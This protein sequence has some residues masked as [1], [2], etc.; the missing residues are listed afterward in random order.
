MRGPEPGQRD[1]PPWGPAAA[2]G[3]AH[4]EQVTSLWSGPSPTLLTLS[5][6]TSSEGRQNIT[7]FKGQIQNLKMHITRKVDKGPSPSHWR[8]GSGGHAG[9]IASAQPTPGPLNLA[10]P[11]MVWL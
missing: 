2:P 4:G 5:A 10:L 1:P 7:D 9:S 11:W 3:R 8:P 6:Q